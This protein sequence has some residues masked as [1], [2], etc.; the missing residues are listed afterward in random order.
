MPA[1]LSLSIIVSVINGKD[2]TNNF[3]CYRA[4]KL[5][6]HEVMVIKNVFKNFLWKG[7]C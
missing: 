7:K 6:K 3:S 4:M 1:E 2:Y 5:L